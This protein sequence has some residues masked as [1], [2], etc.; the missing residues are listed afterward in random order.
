M[1]DF[2]DIYTYFSHNFRTNVATIIATIEAVKLDL[3]DI[4]GDEMNSVYESAYL[5]DLFD[6]SLSICV[7]HI[8]SKKNSSDFTEIEP[9]KYINH[10]INELKSYIEESNYI[11]TK[12]TSDFKAKTN[13]FILKNFIQ[14]IFSE[15][16]R[17]SPNG[18]T[19]KT[20]GKTIAFLPKDK[21]ED[22]PNVYSLFTEI[23]N[24]YNVKFKFN[25][26]EIRFEFK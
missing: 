12:E 17:I 26:K 18:I 24:N 2:K 22:I 10:L 14:L 11:I 5:L 8:S 6:T 3:I 7:D 1:V 15:M 23:L 21:F 19:I 16:F 4:N 20:K 13:E 9:L 25:E